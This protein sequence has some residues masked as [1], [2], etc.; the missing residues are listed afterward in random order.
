MKYG[1]DL[2]CKP[3]RI[4]DI[5]SKQELGRLSLQLRSD[6]A[7]TQVKTNNQLA[8][9]CA[10][11]NLSRLFCNYHSLFLLC[12]FSYTGNNMLMMAAFI[13][14][15]SFFLTICLS[16]LVPLSLERLSKRKPNLLKT[17]LDAAERENRAHRTVS[18]FKSNFQKADE[19]RLRYLSCSTA[20]KQLYPST[21]R[22]N[23]FI[24]FAA[25]KKLSL[26]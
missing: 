11:P 26:T 18:L 5:P 7:H 4:E 23:T 25:M 3:S 10:L 14:L 12:T 20:T 24:G 15:L 22:F 21:R 8:D 1:L 19:A 17:V 16:T 9:L 13:P 6:V 2:R